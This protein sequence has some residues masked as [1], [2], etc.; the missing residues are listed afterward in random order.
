MKLG[1]RIKELRKRLSLT[2]REFAQCIPGK[3]GPTYIGKIER[4]NQYPSLK[5]LERIEKAF[6]VPL[7]YSFEDHGFSKS[8]HLLSGEVK[9]LLKDRKRQD[10]L[11]MTQGLDP[12]HLEV[13]MQLIKILRKEE[14]RYKRVLAG[15]DNYGEEKGKDRAS[16]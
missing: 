8:L 11:K 14:M 15:R 3:V 4:G 2:Q 1:Q 12:E 7:S 9:D 13:V 10:L 5:M 16:R 6:S